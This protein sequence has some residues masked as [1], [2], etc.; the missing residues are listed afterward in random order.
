MK[1]M[2]I[3]VAFLAFANAALITKRETNP[4]KV[5]IM[6]DDVKV[7]PSVAGEVCENC[8][9]FVQKIKD[10]IGDVGDEV[11]KRLPEDFPGVKEICD[12]ISPKVIDFIYNYIKNVGKGIDPVGIC[13]AIFLCPQK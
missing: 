12:S 6:N 2:I 9:A 11:C 3:T 8:Q 1:F 13:R 4:F 7:S 10:T 5:M